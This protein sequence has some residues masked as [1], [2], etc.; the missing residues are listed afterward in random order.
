MHLEGLDDV[1]DE[2]EGNR[3]EWLLF[4]PLFCVMKPLQFLGSQCAEAW[5]CVLVHFISL[6]VEDLLEYDAL[7]VFG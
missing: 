1:A 2:F 7:F 4:P 6:L 5:L 3:S